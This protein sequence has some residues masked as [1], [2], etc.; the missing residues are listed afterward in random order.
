M[1][2]LPLLILLSGVVGL[3]S[4]G[5]DIESR[6]LEVMEIH[7]EVMPMIADMSR[8][9][10]ELEA[11][12]PQRDS[13]DA[14]AVREITRAL[15]QAE[16]GMWDWMAQYRKPNAGDPDALPYQEE[17]RQ[18]IRQVSDDMKSSYQR[19]QQITDPE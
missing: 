5:R 8:K 11:S 19:A 10:R 12:L 16:R 4:C 6:H 13:A 15:M 1:R 3:C 18:K 17:Q 9:R 2:H 7:D 14:E